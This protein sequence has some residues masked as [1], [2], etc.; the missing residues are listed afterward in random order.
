MI[1][2]P[3]TSANKSHKLFAEVRGL[4]IL[5]FC[6][7]CFSVSFYVV[8]L[9]FIFMFSPSLFK[10][11]HLQSNNTYKNINKNITTWRKTKT[12]NKKQQKSPSRN[13]RDINL[14]FAVGSRAGNHVFLFVLCFSLSFMFL[15]VSLYFLFVFFYTFSPSLFK[16]LHLQSN[17]HIYKQ[18][19]ENN[20]KK[21]IKTTT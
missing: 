15:F 2:S 13:L 7:V 6:F 5:Y 8:C 3:R 4:E 16:L 20:S 17:K 19:K 10:L 18:H 14:F 1:S 21:N 12:N 11:L 9:F